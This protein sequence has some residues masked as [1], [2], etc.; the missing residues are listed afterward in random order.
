MSASSLRRRRLLTVAGLL[1]GT[2]VTACAR[3]DAN[4]EAREVARLPAFQEL[5]TPVEIV[6]V[7]RDMFAN[8]LLLRASLYTEAALRRNFGA[9]ATMTRS[10]ELSFGSESIFLQ[11]SVPGRGRI[12][13]YA[14]VIGPRVHS[15]SLGFELDSASISYERTAELFQFARNSDNRLPDETTI[16]SPHGGPRPPPT[17]IHGNKEEAFEFAVGSYRKSFS[18]WFGPD[19][20]L[21][22][23]SISVRDRR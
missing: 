5:T 9:S 11:A 10:K 19:G 16:P 22:S 2:G 15:A 18:C 13:V 14:I 20:T 6:A 7:L 3:E 4:G 12:R 21:A 8:D 23:L 17:N 1:A